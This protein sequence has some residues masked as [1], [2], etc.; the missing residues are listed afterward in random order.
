MK[1]YFFLLTVLGTN[2][3]AS[4]FILPPT[5]DAG[6]VQA[7]LKGML[8]AKLES[9]AESEFGAHLSG[10]YGQVT[11]EDRGGKIVCQEFS[12]GQLAVQMFTCEVSLNDESSIQY[13][14]LR[15][16]LTMNSGSTQATL[17]QILFEELEANGPVTAP[18]EANLTGSYSQVT[19]EDA[20]TQVVCSER[21][22]GTLAVQQFTC[23]FAAKK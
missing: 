2:L 14:S 8:H 7:K 11:L 15:F 19:L 1:R 13:P 17:K 18:Y 9:G 3:F 20:S 4:T 22:H 10:D 21:S 23:E 6:S 5:M 12:A 16:P